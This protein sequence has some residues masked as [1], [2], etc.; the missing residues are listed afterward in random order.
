MR[1]N[2]SIHTAVTLFAA[3]NLLDIASTY[4]AL[5]AGF[6]EGNWLP[7]LLLSMGGEPAM[8]LFKALVSLL[9]IAAV[10]RLSPHFRRLDY[11]LHAANA[12]LALTVA[13]NVLQLLVA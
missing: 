3:L 6:S 7:S 1:P 10:I 11:G 13:Q 2:S 12:V 4:V 5:Q 9:V 8:F